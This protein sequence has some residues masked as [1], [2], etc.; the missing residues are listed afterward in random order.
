FRGWL[1][2]G[3]GPP[4]KIGPERQQPVAQAFGVLAVDL[5][6][7]ENA[8]E[9]C[10]IAGLAPAMIMDDRLIG[11]LD[12]LAALFGKEDLERL[13]AEIP[14]GCPDGAANDRIEVDQLLA[15]QEI[16]DRGLSAGKGG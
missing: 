6:V 7:G 3:L 12:V 16:V 10:L 1:G 9:Q 13:E 14:F 4:G 5:V 8:V 15:S 2:T 11:F